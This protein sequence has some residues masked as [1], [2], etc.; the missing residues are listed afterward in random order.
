MGEKKTKQTQSVQVRTRNPRPGETCPPK[1]VLVLRDRL[2]N[3]TLMQFLFQLFFSHYFSF[4][5][6]IRQRFCFELFTSFVKQKLEFADDTLFFEKLMGI[7]TIF[8]HFID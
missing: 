3:P 7:F 2:M 5:L 4:Q 6:F 8:L 1:P